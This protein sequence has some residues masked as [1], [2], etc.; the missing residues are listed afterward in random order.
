[1]RLALYAIPI[2]AFFVQMLFILQ[3]MKC[4]TSPD[5][6]SLRYGDPL[7]Q[8]SI[9]FGG[10]GGFL[11]RLSS[12]LLFWQ[13][14]AHCCNARSMSFSS[15]EG[16]NSDLTG[17]MSLL[18]LF[19]LTLCTSQLLETL[20]CALQG[21]QPMPETALTI[22]EHS[23]AFAE[24]EAMI[25]SALGLGFFGLDNNSSTT[26]SA[27]STLIKFTKSELLRRLNVPPEVLLVCLISCFSHLS[28]ATLAVSGQRHKVRLINT[29]I[30]SFCYMS[31][32]V[33]SFVKVL[34]RPVSNASELGVLRFPTVCIVGFIPHLLILCGMIVCGFVYGVALIVTAFSVPREAAN[35]LT[36]RQR[37]RWAYRN[38]QAN[39]HFSSSS[40]IRIKMSED[41]YT[42][43]LKVGFNVLTAASEAVYLNE[44]SRVHVADMT[45]LERKRIGELATSME[46]RQRSKIPSELLGEDIARGVG[47]V[48][49]DGSLFGQSPYARE[50]KSKTTS[51]DSGRPGPGELDSGLGMTQRRSRMH[52]TLD[53]VTGVFWLVIGLQA[54]FVLHLLASSGFER[55]P[56]WL[57]KAAGDFDRHQRIP[58]Q[59]K[60]G[61]SESRSALLGGLN[62]MPPLAIQQN[63]NVDVEVEVRSWLRAAGQPDEAKVNDTLYRLW[64]EGA[65]F[66]SI[67]SSG[68]FAT[69]DADD[70]TTS[71]VSLSTNAEM[72]D[73]WSD[74][75]ESGRRTPTQTHPHSGHPQEALIDSDGGLD[76]T[77]LSRLLDP[78]SPA[79]R[80]EARLLSYSLQSSRPVTRS[81]YQRS[82]ERNRA[83]LLASLRSR[84]K[85]S[86][87][88]ED[89]ERDLEHFILEQRCKAR[90]KTAGTWESGAEGMG[91][92]GPQC[93]VCQSTPRTILVWPCGCLS[94]CDECR[95]GLAARNYTKCICCRTDIAAYSRLYVP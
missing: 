7:K 62:G 25:S 13:D 21:Q 79:D 9:D 23:L 53:F 18:Y 88:D 90:A 35:G 47:F 72:D 41:F 89:E 30:W 31:A 16:N 93:V 87:D 36:L 59:T 82:L 5:F 54:Q 24:C 48:D 58:A 28:S 66:G 4:Q 26:S 22:F 60:A 73:D 8:L 56:A 71:M 51:K 76:A 10:E 38:L 80:E 20:V 52:L 70:D 19:F 11:Y 67:D 61:H 32:F 34:L 64:Q 3:A 63:E 39:V 33:W 83:G 17:S 85:A 91:A 1:M 69:Q 6:P 65:W 68:D 75:D 27:S 84:N 92:G 29:A 74:F 55:R 12:T 57:I 43:L 40:S 78:Q 37:F 86:T 77:L 50:R 49:Q 2:T 15:V 45:W 94:M 14:D 81:Q 46:R 42:T 44:G 95:V